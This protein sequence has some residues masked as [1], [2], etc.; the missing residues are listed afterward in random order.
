MFLS[1]LVMQPKHKSKLFKRGKEKEKTSMMIN[2][3]IM[4]ALR[5][6]SDESGDSVSDIVC[7]F[8]DEYLT[9]LVTAGVLQAPAEVRSPISAKVDE[10][11]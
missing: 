7:E 10:A 5:M 8:L 3:P 2:K 1:Q 11:G 9:A 4:D 6:L